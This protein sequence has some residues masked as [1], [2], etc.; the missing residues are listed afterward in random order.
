[1]TSYLIKCC[2][3]IVDLD[4]KPKWCIKCGIHDVD[5]IEFT[6]DTMLSCPFCGGSPTAECLGSIPM[7]WYECDKCT[8]SSGSGGD[9]AEARDNWNKRK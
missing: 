6:E 9:W 8:A 4:N 2:N 7:Y 1:M 5:V 3:R